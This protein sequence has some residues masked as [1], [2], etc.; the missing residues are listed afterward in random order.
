MG[1]E[2]SLQS[3]PVHCELLTESAVRQRRKRF[4]ALADCCSVVDAPEVC[5]G[6][7]TACPSQLP[8]YALPQCARPS[9]CKLREREVS[10]DDLKLFQG[11]GSPVRRYRHRRREHSEDVSCGV[12]QSHRSCY[13]ATICEE[14][15]AADEWRR[16]LEYGAA[17]SLD[18]EPVILS[19]DAVRWSLRVRGR[20]TIYNLAELR[21]CEDLPRAYGSGQADA[22]ELVV[23][24]ADM[25][26]LVFQ[27]DEDEI[28]AAFAQVMNQLALD[29]RLSTPPTAVGAAPGSGYVNGSDSETEEST[30]FRAVGAEEAAV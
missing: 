24:F 14:G 26:P 20:D 15:D 25:E 4:T 5:A 6:R 28:R 11:D 29:A 27:F 19:L 1:A 22:Y 10:E 16:C 3:L 13:A 18:G 2:Q 21:S 30:G 12:P 7:K 17:V 8:S 9:P 23:S